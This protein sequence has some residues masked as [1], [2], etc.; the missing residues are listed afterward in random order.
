MSLNDFSKTR[1]RVT[2]ITGNSDYGKLV[3]ASVSRI[4]ALKYFKYVGV[5]IRS[6]QTMQVPSCII[7][8]RSVEVIEQQLSGKIYHYEYGIELGIALKG[9]NDCVLFQELL[10]L[11]AKL[12]TSFSIG[13]STP[14]LTFDSVTGHFNTRVGSTPVTL[15][16]ELGRESLLF[17]S[18]VVVNFDVRTKQE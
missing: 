10:A 6:K 15:L 4:H 7:L 9:S 14:V 2:R 12:R 18:G 13:T 3:L 5:L 11:A 8:P 16:E 17:S 1:S